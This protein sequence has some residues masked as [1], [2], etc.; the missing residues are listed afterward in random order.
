MSKKYH[1]LDAKPESV[2]VEAAALDR[3]KPWMHKL[4]AERPAP[5]VETP[6]ERADR[7][8]AAKEAQRAAP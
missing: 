8:R 5:V 4:D 6:K 3:S 2:E 7:R 1:G